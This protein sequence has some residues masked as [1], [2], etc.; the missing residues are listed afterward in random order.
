TSTR[1]RP[2]TAA[3]APWPS[4]GT[5]H[6]SAD[7]C[8]PNDSCSPPP[9][10]T[11]RTLIFGERH[12]RTVLPATELN[13]PHDPGALVSLVQEHLHGQPT[14]SGNQPRA[15]PKVGGA[16]SKYCGIYQIRFGQIPAPLQELPG[17]RAHV[18]G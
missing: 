17:R 1:P 15:V 7:N 2:E 12:R 18:P 4:S 11:D 10:P 6:G 16:V 5:R 3:Q 14:R 13:P 8:S 9:E